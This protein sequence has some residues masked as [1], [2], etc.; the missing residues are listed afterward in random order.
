MRETMPDPLSPPTT[1]CCKLRHGVVVVVLC[2]TCA[3]EDRPRRK[4]IGFQLSTDPTI[5]QDMVKLDSGV[6]LQ[7]CHVTQEEVKFVRPRQYIG[8]EYVHRPTCKRVTGE[9]A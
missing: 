2:C 4:V 8:R 5:R 6:I 1:E 7:T 9:S 3:P